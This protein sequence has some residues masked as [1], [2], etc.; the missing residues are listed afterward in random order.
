MADW[1]YDLSKVNLSDPSG[2]APWNKPAVKLSYDPLNNNEAK[3]HVA[4]LWKLFS[5]LYSNAL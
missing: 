5:K 4:G 2:N 3:K 1:V